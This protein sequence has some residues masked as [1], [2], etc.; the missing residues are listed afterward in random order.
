[1]KY[2]ALFLTLISFTFSFQNLNSQT[3]RKIQIAILFDTSN[4]MDGL[5]EQAKSRIWN[6]VNDLGTLRH[7]GEVPK[8]EI[9]L[10]DYGNDGI[11]ENTNYIRQILPLSS[12]LDLLSQ[13]LFAL[14]TNGGSEF[15]GA[16][17]EKSVF[18]L[19]WTE[20]SDDLKMIYIAGNEPFNQ[21]P[22]D[23]KLA[24]EKARKKNIYINTIYCG[25]Y[26]MGIKELW[27]DGANKGKGEYFNIDSDVAVRFIAS[28]YDDQI[29]LYNDSLNST[30]YGYGR[31]GLERKNMQLSQDANASGISSANQTERSVAKSKSYYSN[32]SWDLLDGLAN[33]TISIDS[34]KKEDLP[35][36]FQNLTK[37]Q[38]EKV[39]D[40]KQLERTKCQ[41]NIADL[42]VLRED[43]IAKE[44]EKD[45]ENMDKD[46]LGAKISESINTK[47][48]ELNFQKEK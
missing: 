18:D 10:Y 29:K 19:A 33:N 20:S 48:T 40:E 41:K 22:I 28:P 23:Y 37:V 30:Y 2:L 17:I 7:N 31:N 15:C 39:L 24:I 21:G 45:S 36:E 42:A 9:G 46:D 11:V 13:K 5:I 1:M 47:A 3:T 4:S 8:I 6:I 14:T 43:F 32:S 44:R 12:D 34:L 35:K 27:Q 38:L 26:E 25:P 16:V